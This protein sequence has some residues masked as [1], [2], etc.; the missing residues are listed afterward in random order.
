MSSAM[1]VCHRVAP[2]LR[3]CCR[4][5]GSMPR[6]AVTVR[7]D[8]TGKA[9]MNWATM[10]AI[11]VKSQLRNPKGPLWERARKT[12]KPTTTVGKAMPA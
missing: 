6:M 8:M 3:S 2:R 7:L 12:T 5:P 10:I 11:G 4:I 9:M 1:E